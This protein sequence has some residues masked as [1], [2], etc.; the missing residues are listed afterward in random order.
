MKKAFGL[1][2]FKTYFSL[3]IFLCNSK[4]KKKLLDSK[5]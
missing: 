4:E 1:Y 3:E 2:N 5:S